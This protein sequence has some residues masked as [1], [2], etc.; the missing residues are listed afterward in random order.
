MKPP[1]QFNREQA[2]SYA[3]RLLNQRG[4]SEYSLKQKLT[5]HSVTPEDSASIIAKLKELRFLD[6][7][8]LAENLYR[9]QSRHRHMSSRA[10]AYKLQQKGIHRT[11]I[12]Q[13]LKVD[14]DVP[15]EQDRAQTLATR[16]WEKTKDL[17]HQKRRER[18]MSFL[19]RRG[20]PSSVITIVARRIIQA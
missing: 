3:L 15:S 12:D 5:Q 4:Y 10:I 6:D 2:W 18:L 13:T 8:A 20:F 19:Y 11:I 7:R 17:P 16:Y 9:S 1:R 14:N